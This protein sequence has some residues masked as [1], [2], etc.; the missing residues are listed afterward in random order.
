MIGASHVEEASRKRKY[1]ASL[2][3]ERVKEAIKK[4]IFWVETDGW[5]VGQLNGLSVLQTG[6]HVFGQPNR[7]T[8]TV[9]VG[10][11]GAISIDREARM[12]GAT[13]T[14]GLLTLG[15]FIQG[16]VCA[17][18]APGPFR[19]PFLRAELRYDRRRQRIEHRL[20]ALLSAISGVPIYQGIAVTGSVSQ[21]GE[22]QPIG[23]VNYKIKGFFD[24]CRHK[25]FTGAR[26][27]SSHR[28][29]CAISCSTR[30][31]SRR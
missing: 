10:K 12:S 21:K 8:A 14:K 3:E 5:K 22:I 30:K 4:D 16:E 27:L 15:S 6:D 20:Y 13:H 25:G 17:E 1:R 9:S 11:E 29:T 19:S 26:V 24:I 2:Y 28:R 18:Q 31:L 23:G 7:I